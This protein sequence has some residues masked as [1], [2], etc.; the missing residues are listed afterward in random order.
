MAVKHISLCSTR[1]VSFKQKANPF[2]K[3]WGKVK[4][5]RLRGRGQKSKQKRDREKENKR[6]KSGKI[7]IAAI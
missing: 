2:E 6:K 5:E 1:N 7:Y 4:I 3:N